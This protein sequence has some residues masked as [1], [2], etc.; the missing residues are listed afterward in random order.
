MLVV[1]NL[2]YIKIRFLNNFNNN[3]KT[4]NNEVNVVMEEAEWVQ[5]LDP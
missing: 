2:S 3:I 1:T 4:G 5:N